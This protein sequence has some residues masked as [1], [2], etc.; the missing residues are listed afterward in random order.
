MRGDACPISTKFNAVVL[1]TGRGLSAGRG[2]AAVPSFLAFSI[3][4]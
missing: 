1:G 3:A 2:F 4:S